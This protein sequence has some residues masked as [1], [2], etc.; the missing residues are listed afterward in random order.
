VTRAGA[1]RCARIAWVVLAVCVVLAGCSERDP[2]GASA[3]PDFEHPDLDGHPLRLSDLRGRTVVIDFWATWCAPC[4]FQPG[5]LNQVWAAHRRAGDVVVLGIEVGGASAEEIRA[6]GEDNDAIAQYP[7]L[8]GADEDL[9]RQYGVL[10]FPATVVIDP[11]GEIA[12]LHVGLTTAAEV[13]ATISEAGS[14]IG[15]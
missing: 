11:E 12:A 4:A 8:V 6:W 2:A 3:A 9:A 15:S 13:E 10:G 14:A 1:R 5:E 7:V